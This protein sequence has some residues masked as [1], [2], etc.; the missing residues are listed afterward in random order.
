M[1]DPCLS[2]GMMKEIFYQQTKKISV[3]W[4]FKPSLMKFCETFKSRRQCEIIK[5]MLYK[6]YSKKNL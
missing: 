6:R 2:A 1:F 3:F 5:R 4:A